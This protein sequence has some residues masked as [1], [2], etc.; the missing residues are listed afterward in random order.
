MLQ[1][2][3]LIMV[4]ISVKFDQERSNHLKRKMKLNKFV[5]FLITMAMAVILNIV[6]IACNNLSPH[7]GSCEVAW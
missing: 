5:Y 1:K 6:N 4:I 3:R 2:H 7:H